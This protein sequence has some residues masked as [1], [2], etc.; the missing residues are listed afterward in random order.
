MFI[1]QG[2]LELPLNPNYNNIIRFQRLPSAH[3]YCPRGGT[4][5]A[6]AT[7]AGA[8][9]AL[10]KQLRNH[11]IWT[12]L[13][14]IKTRAFTHYQSELAGMNTLQEST[15]PTP[16]QEAYSQSQAFQRHVSHAPLTTQRWSPQEAHQNNS[17]TGNNIHWS[18][19][20]FL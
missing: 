13:S 15:P 14:A 3:A 9:Q 12:R 16:R 2:I 5:L 4:S 7:T 6:T 18:S 17:M 1:R 8:N 11:S 19:I 20:I 10:S